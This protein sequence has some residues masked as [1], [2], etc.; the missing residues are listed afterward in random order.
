MSRRSWPASTPSM[1]RAPTI[2][3]TSSNRAG[4]S[5][6][7]ATG[8]AAPGTSDVT[9]NVRRATSPVTSLDRQDR[10][11]GDTGVAHHLVLPAPLRLVE[12]LVRTGDELVERGAAGKV[13]RAEARGNTDRLAARAVQ[14]ERGDGAADL[15]RNHTGAFG[16][17]AR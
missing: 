16:R 12:T 17:R 1:P 10:L 14:L 4:C 13:R 8:A 7:T 5:R 6:H 2:S 9:D 3:H 11:P 15:F